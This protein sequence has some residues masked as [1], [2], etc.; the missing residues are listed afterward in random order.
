MAAQLAEII[1]CANQLWPEQTAENWDRVGLIAGVPSEPVARVLLAVDISHKTVTEAEEIGADLLLSHHPLLLRGVHSVAATEYK[2]AL[3]TRL[4]RN[5]IAAYAAHTNADTP[6][7]GVSAVLADALNLQDQAPL[8]PSEQ[9]SQTGIGRV[10]TLPVPLKLADLA[11]KLAQVLPATAGGV[12]AAGSRDKTVSRV[13]LCAG[14]GDS[15]LNNP[16]VQSADVYITSDLRH[17]PAQ[18]FMENSVLFHGCALLDIAHW[19]AESLWLSAAAKQLQ[20]LLPQ[21]EF[22]VSSKNTDPWDFVTY[23]TA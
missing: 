15:L 18:E 4:I 3:L 9:D 7:A 21:V 16:R 22:V 2:G 14:A 12:R 6:P 17:H 5:K 13:A 11:H 10:G 19:A 23:K 1:S 20:E 8:V